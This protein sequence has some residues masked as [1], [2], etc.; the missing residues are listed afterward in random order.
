MK[1][2]DFAAQIDALARLEVGEPARDGYG[3]RLFE[4]DAQ[5]AASRL[6]RLSAAIRGIAWAHHARVEARRLEALAQ[7]HADRVAGEHSLMGGRVPTFPGFY[8]GGSYC[9]PVG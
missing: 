6:G 3:Q 4:T 1:L 8:S 7:A 9:P 2:A 5:E